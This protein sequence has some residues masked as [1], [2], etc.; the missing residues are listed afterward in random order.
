MDSR[1]DVYWGLVLFLHAI[2]IYTHGVFFE[3]FEAF[4]NY[5]I[6]ESARLNIP[7]IQTVD[8]FPIYWLFAKLQSMLGS[9]SVFFLW[10]VGLNILVLFFV[11]KI[12]FQA[13]NHAFF[14][15]VFVFIAFF[16]LAENVFLLNN[17]RVSLLLPSV[18][19]LYLYLF[20][21]KLDLPLLIFIIVTLLSLTVR[22]HSPLF[23]FLV[24]FCIAIIFKKGYLAKLSTIGIFLSLLFIAAFSYVNHLDVDNLG[25]FNNYERSIDDRGGFILSG[26][27]LD[28]NLTNEELKIFAKALFIMDEPALNHIEYKDIL[29]H[30]TFTEY[31]FA[32]NFLKTYSKNALEFSR[33]LWTD[34]KFNLFIVLFLVI[35]ILIK[36]PSK[37]RFSLATLFF[38]L[39]P[40]VLLVLAEVY[41]TFIGP[42]LFILSFIG[43]CLIFKTYKISHYQ[44]MFFILF[45]FVLSFFQFQS[46]GLPRIKN[47][48]QKHQNSIDLMNQ[49][50]NKNEQV[51]LLSIIDEGLFHSSLF[52]DWDK[53]QC[54]EF[55]DY[56]HLNYM[57]LFSKKN[58][59]TFGEN[60]KSLKHKFTYIANEIGYLYAD[61]FRIE[62]MTFYLKRIHD[63]KVGYELE[64]QNINKDLHKYKIWIK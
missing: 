50:C 35:L 6:Y 22:I 31:L 4:F 17:L 1:N 49:F 19:L 51:I 21:R 7:I 48:I 44:K 40:F 45:I 29:H 37:L 47:E 58:E 57:P 26:N 8:N 15:L 38:I 23:V 62:F 24:A 59:L 28:E 34:Y 5:A 46:N 36:F 30:T 61:E 12:I 9:V 13:I 43:I 53:N 25:D 64:K 27:P 42:F 11:Y 63:L 2:F 18:G 32:K 52:A 10:R 14:K 54:F 3:S 41:N 20:R 55:L 33:V 60:F 16:L 39:L 56:G